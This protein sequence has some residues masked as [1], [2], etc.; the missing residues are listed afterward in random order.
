[1][2]FPQLKLMVTRTQPPSLCVHLKVL[3]HKIAAKSLEAEAVITIKFDHT[4]G[5]QLIC[6]NMQL[7]AECL[8]VPW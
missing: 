5:V 3:S 6:C 8:H 7:A 4:T 1:M 2:K